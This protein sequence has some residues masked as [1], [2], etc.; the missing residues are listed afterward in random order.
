M[1]KGRSYPK[2]V[3][4]AFIE[5]KRKNCQILRLRI[6]P[7]NSSQVIQFVLILKVETFV[8]DVFRQTP[9]YHEVVEDR[10]EVE[11]PVAKQRIAPY[12]YDAAQS[13]L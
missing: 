6:E 9:H 2:N 8:F 11:L 7:S 13:L 12:F 10:Q 1:E 5:F 4:L 3:L